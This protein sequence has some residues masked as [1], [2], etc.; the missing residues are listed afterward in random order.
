MEQPSTEDTYVPR[1]AR[2]KRRADEASR[3]SALAPLLTIAEV[4]AY[5]G[6]PVQTLYTWRTEGKGPKA[7]K[8]GKHLR[9]RL[10]DLNA[11]LDEQAA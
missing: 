2:G 1:K 5:L 10:E 3:S 11:W 6:I 9:F 8:V 4:S 7:Y